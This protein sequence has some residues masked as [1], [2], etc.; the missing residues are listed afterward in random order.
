[1]YFKN[2]DLQVIQIA[3]THN[4]EQMDELKRLLKNEIS[5]KAKKILKF[6]FFLCGKK[7][8][9]SH[10]PPVIVFKLAVNCYIYIPTWHGVSVMPS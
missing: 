10:L 8:N 9:R 1:M 6:K 5:N 7:S 4:L 2:T 3:F